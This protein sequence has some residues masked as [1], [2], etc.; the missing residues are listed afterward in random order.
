M[1]MRS[2]LHLPLLLGAVCISS[3]ASAQQAWMGFGGDAWH[4]G[5]SKTASLAMDSIVWSKPVDLNPPYSGDHLLAH[6]GS[7][8]IT[9]GNTV[10]VPVKVGLDDG[11]KVVAYRGSDGTK[12]WS[13]NTTY[14]IPPHGWYP[15]YNVTLLPPVSG[16]SVY[17]VAWPESGG[18]IAIRSTADGGPATKQYINFYG[19]GKYNSR[20]KAQYDANVKISTP[21]TAGP[22]GSIYFGFEIL[23]DTPGFLKSGLA[24]IDPNG[25]GT[26]VAADVL[27][28][29]LE[30]QHVKMQSAPAVSR[31]GKR[32]YTVVATGNFGR[33]KLVSIRTSDMHPLARTNL[34]DP[35]SGNFASVDFDGTASPLIG[36]DGDVFVGVLENPFP[37]NNYRGWLLHFSGDLTEQKT[38]GAFGW[39]NTASIVPSSIVPFYTGTSS[40]L[41]FTKYN[42]YAIGGGAGDNRIA[43]IDPNDVRPD[44][45][46]GVKVMKVIGSKLGPTLDPN[47]GGDARMEWCVNVGVVDVKG[48]CLLANSEDGLVYRWDLVA[49]KLSESIRITE[50]LGQ[51]YT[52]T[53]IGPDGKI[54]AT[55]NAKLFAI[56]TK[57]RS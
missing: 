24:K 50:G 28:D 26:Y 43:L 55:N 17:R 11:F 27:G 42:D 47:A 10:V 40:Y 46:S 9:P 15:T 3:F 52:S 48:K 30:L 45:V 23:G 39:D 34:I 38:P 44:P 36:P 41:L 4:S 37:N 8:V 2:S 57:P 53:L 13:A 49:N 5:Q 32:V 25:V 51:A 18:R 29:D 16:S 6:Y 1:T 31:D 56:G 7:P 54:Y 22:D 19:A 20:T 14:S 21:L 33:G 12:L 35:L